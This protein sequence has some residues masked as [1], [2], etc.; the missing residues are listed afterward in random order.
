MSFDETSLTFTIDGTDSDS[1]FF[2]QEIEKVIWL[3][4]TA[5]SESESAV[6]SYQVTLINPSRAC[7]GAILSLPETPVSFKE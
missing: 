5:S 1:L 3:N 4:I 7:F 6:K 2:D